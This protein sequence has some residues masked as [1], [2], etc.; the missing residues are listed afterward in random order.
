[1]PFIFPVSQTLIKQIEVKTSKQKFLFHY[2]FWHEGADVAEPHFEDPELNIH[3]H[4][5]VTNPVKDGE[6]VN[7]D[8]DEAEIKAVLGVFD[9]ISM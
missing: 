6:I 4:L 3:G 1:M 5:T 7:I 9:N 2:W 8:G